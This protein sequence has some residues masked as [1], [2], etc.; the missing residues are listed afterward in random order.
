MS[1]RLR[2]VSLLSLVPLQENPKQ[3]CLWN[4]IRIIHIAFIDSESMGYLFFCCQSVAMDNYKQHIAFVYYLLI[5]AFV[6]SFRLANFGVFATTQPLFCSEPEFIVIQPFNC[7]RND[8][9]GQ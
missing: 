7:P 4:F 3:F 1:E 2:P 6:L 9:V 5:V 8:G